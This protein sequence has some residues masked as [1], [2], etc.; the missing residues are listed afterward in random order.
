M[1]EF[2]GAD[3]THPHPLC[4]QSRAGAASGQVTWFA[5]ACRMG[6]VICMHLRFREVK[7]FA[8]GH[9]AGK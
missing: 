7:G 5:Q 1:L 2:P 3:S 6:V 9:T 4:S 8:Y